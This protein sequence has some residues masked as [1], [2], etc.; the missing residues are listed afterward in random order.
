MVAVR[1]ALHAPIASRA[2]PA[3]GGAPPADANLREAF[4]ERFASLAADP[5]SFHELVTSV[6]GADHDRAAAEDL[7]RRTLDGDLSWLPPVRLVSRE[8]L[9]GANGAYD[10]EAGVVFLARDLDP[11]TARETFIEEVGHHL[12]R[13]LRPT[14]AAGDEG[15]LFRRLLGGERLDAASLR[16]IR[17]EDDRGVITVDGRRVEVE[18]WNPLGGLRDAVEGVVEGLTSVARGVARA[19]GD[20]FGGL[21]DG[22]GGLLEGLATGDLSGAF[23]RLGAGLDRAF[24]RSSRGLLT[25]V[26][27]AA[28]AMV[29]G[30]TRLLPPFLGAPVRRLTDRLMDAARSLVGGAVDVFVNI[31]RN[32]A[33]GAAQALRG[34]GRLATGDL[35]G[36]LADLGI[37]LLKSTVQTV[38]DALLLGLG[39]GV[40]AV[41]TAIGLEPPGRALR[42]DEVAL[43][44]TVYGDSI[45]Y[46]EV[47]IKEGDAGLFSLNERAFV[48]GNTVYLKGHVGDPE[49][50]VHELAHVWQFQNGGSDY[51]TEALVSQEWGKGYD[52]Q[53][54]VPGTPFAELEPEQQAQ[55]IGNAFA[56]GYFTGGATRFVYDGVDYTE[57]LE[58]ALA[59]VRA[60][61]GAP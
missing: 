2:A 20:F 58:G 4:R 27:G 49:T 34:L 12:D 44:R 9:G 7:R 39:K 35:K 3:A 21:A 15:E 48:H 28:E 53:A 41:Q 59:D 6:F 51:M 22:F 50:L 5:S 46:D 54:S 47:R 45:D 33:E 32:T 61:R 19:A 43:L 17:A 18:F 8:T 40:S 57:Y 56:S 16:A 10:G 13:L 11:A 23:G 36:G 38:A 29:D 55:L 52:W 14:D 26:W 37:G 42:P 30:A 1:P 31:V 25:G 60:G 24:L